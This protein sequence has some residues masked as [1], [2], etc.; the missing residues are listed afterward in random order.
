[1]EADRKLQRTHLLELRSAMTDRAWREGALQQ[2]V[3]DWLQQ[4]A[5]HVVGFFF[6]IRGEPDLRTVIAE[7]LAND[8]RRIAALPVVSNTGDDHL[9][10]YHSW[11]AD[12]PMQA[13]SF[14]IPVPAQGRVVQPECLLI[15]C[16]G[17]DER[18]FRLGYGG[19]YYDRTLSHLVPWPL[20][21]GIAFDNTKV[22]SI[23]PQPHDIR[24][25]VVIT[26]AGQY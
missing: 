22:G 21:V 24:L 7:W 5:M 12:S 11:T 14:G 4:A 6:P 23:D 15:P 3:A 25:D 1:M 26:D 18:R 19:G 2:R 9:L 13:G 16:V 10:D 8:S 20:A 17:F